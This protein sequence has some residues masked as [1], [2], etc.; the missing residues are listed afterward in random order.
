MQASSTGGR[1]SLLAYPCHYV[2]VK[3]FVFS[4]VTN[5]APQLILFQFHGIALGFHKIPVT[6]RHT[7][8]WGKVI[9]A[10]WHDVMIQM[11]LVLRVD[12]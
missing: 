6:M 1:C 7:V 3:V 11:M 10:E 2:K 8:T 9:K 5:A 4:L 12:H